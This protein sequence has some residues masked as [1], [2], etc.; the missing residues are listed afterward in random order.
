MS[1][2]TSFSE[3]P[4]WIR[5]FSIGFVQILTRKHIKT[6]CAQIHTSLGYTENVI[7]EES[8]LKKIEAAGQVNGDNDL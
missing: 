7:P 2:F 6:L 1:S 4:S 5:E 8:F 3:S